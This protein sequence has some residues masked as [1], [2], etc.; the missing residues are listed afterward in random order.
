MS[1]YVYVVLA[2]LK[3]ENFRLLLLVTNFTCRKVFNDPTRAF[4]TVQTDVKLAVKKLVSV[5]S[6]KRKL[7]GNKEFRV[8]VGCRKALLFHRN[9]HQFRPIPFAWKIRTISI[10]HICLS[11]SHWMANVSMMSNECKYACWKNHNHVSGFRVC[12]C[13]RVQMCKCGNTTLTEPQYK[14]IFAHE[15][16]K[17]HVIS[18]H[19]ACL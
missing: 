7:N 8:H 13:S 10:D 9:Y 4:K 3:W 14:K 17:K 16:K 19:T 18:D 2:S 15:K 6:E 1:I 12:A 5:K 11:A